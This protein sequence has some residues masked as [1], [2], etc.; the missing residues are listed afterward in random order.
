MKG[1]GRARCAVRRLTAAPVVGP[2]SEPFVDVEGV[3]EA[4]GR[5][6]CLAIPLL[7]VGAIR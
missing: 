3:V 1:V 2:A 7:D 4:R 6:F 5:R